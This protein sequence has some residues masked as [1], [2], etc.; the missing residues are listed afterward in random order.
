MGGPEVGILAFSIVSIF[1]YYDTHLC[2][3]TGGTYLRVNVVVHILDIIS[4]TAT[5]QSQSQNSDFEISSF[6]MVPLVHIRFAC[7]DSPRSFTSIFW[8]DLW[9]LK[10]APVNYAFRFGGPVTTSPPAVPGMVSESPNLPARCSAR[11]KCS[12]VPR[13]F[14]LQ[15]PHSF[16]PRPVQLGSS[17]LGE[18]HQRSNHPE[19]LWG[20]TNSYDRANEK[21]GL[22][23]PYCLRSLRALQHP[24][25]SDAAILLLIRSPSIPLSSPTS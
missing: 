6:K 18:L 16:S 8:Y 24:F 17:C 5:L 15:L 25:I 19:V 14:S 2:C 7:W 9:W 23:R 11:Y 22:E 4:S 3:S 12:L 20:P 1:F 10:M 13:R 21:N